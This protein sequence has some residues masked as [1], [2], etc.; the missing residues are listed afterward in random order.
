MVLMTDFQFVATPLPS[1]WPKTYFVTEVIP[2]A[3]IWVP[4]GSGARF[5]GTRR[6]LQYLKFLFNVPKRAISLHKNPIG[7]AGTSGAGRIGTVPGP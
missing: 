6:L 4:G 7:R 1:G 5:C 3:Q 2:S